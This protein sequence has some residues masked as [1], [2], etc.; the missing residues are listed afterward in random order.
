VEERP[1]TVEEPSS[2]LEVTAPVEV[3]APV[4]P[5]AVMPL[6]DHLAELRRRIIWSALAIALGG[7]I[8]VRGWTGDHRV[9]QRARS[10]A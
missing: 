9:P 6:V 3:A 4:E 10:R 1:S 2:S 7:V 5:G 8:G